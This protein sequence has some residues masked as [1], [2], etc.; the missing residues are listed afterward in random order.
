MIFSAY[1][2]KPVQRI[3]KYQ[4]LLEQLVKHVNKQENNHD[5][6]K[7]ALEVMLKCLRSV[8]DSMKNI[9]GYTVSTRII[10]FNCLYP[11]LRT[12]W[13]IWEDLFTTV[14]LRLRQ[15]EAE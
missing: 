4:L 5:Q 7:E 13:P 3:T 11:I 15:N 6:L 1:L 9:T 8:T 14:R 12:I 10:Y 2:L